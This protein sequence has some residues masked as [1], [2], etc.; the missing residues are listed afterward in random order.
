VYTALSRPS[1]KDHRASREQIRERG[2][3]Q[4][5]VITAVGLLSAKRSKTGLSI[6]Q[7]VRPKN[8]A[9]RGIYPSGPDLERGDAVRPKNPALPSCLLPTT[10]GVELVLFHPRPN[11]L[12][13]FPERL[14]AG[15]KKGLERVSRSGEA[16]ARS[17]TG[18]TR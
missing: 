1:R 4:L 9:T 14:P 15:R 12:Q 7:G 11:L 16:A 5:A 17:A 3:W 6:G 18:R 10:L 2:G 8:K 13:S